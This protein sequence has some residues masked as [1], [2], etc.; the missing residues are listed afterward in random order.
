MDSRLPKFLFVLLAV[1]AAVRF[2]S[3]YPQLPDVVASHFNAR[4][5]QRLANEIRFL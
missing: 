2:S 1:Y 4:H 5:S 3:Y